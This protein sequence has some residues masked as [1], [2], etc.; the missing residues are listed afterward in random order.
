MPPGRSIGRI[1][2]Q[3]LGGIGAVGAALGAMGLIRGDINGLTYLAGGLI[4]MA[5]LVSWMLRASPKQEQ[6]P[7]P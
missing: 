5:P 6:E 7:R 2:L 1:W 3:V 4:L